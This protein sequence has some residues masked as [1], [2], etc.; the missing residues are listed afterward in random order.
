M[1]RS[2]AHTNLVQADLGVG[3]ALVVEAPPQG[4]ILGLV[5]GNI[6]TFRPEG[7]SEAGPSLTSSVYQFNSPEVARTYFEEAEGALAEE[8]AFSKASVGVGCMALSYRGGGDLNGLVFQNRNA[9]VNLLLEG[10]VSPDLE[11]AELTRLA[12]T[13]SQRI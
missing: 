5:D 3:W 12:T 8:D 7:S 13:I 9:M 2:P 4:E 10:G 11:A 1:M 6:R